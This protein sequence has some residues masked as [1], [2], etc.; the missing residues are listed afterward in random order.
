M[1]IDK[2]SCVSLGDSFLG[3]PLNTIDVEGKMRALIRKMFQGKR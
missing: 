2:T 1:R 3:C